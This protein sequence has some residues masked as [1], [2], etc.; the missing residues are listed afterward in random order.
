MDKSDILFNVINSAS[1][2]F[3][4]SLLSLYVTLNLSVYSF[5]IL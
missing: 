4:K 5:G 3:L 1:Q 2:N